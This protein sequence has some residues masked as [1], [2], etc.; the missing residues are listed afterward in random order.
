MDMTIADVCQTNA[1]G[2]YWATPEHQ[3]WKRSA[4]SNHLMPQG[5]EEFG[6]ASWF[7]SQICAIMP[8][9]IDQLV[10]GLSEVGFTKYGCLL[11]CLTDRT[12][13]LE[14]GRQE[15]IHRVDARPTAIAMSSSW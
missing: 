2:E 3:R 1:F 13:D 11:S 9:S 15:Q 8:F 10:I 5:F 4:I 12:L 14:L 7:C 6:K